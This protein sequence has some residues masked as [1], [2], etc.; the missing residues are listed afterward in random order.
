MN[1][2]IPNR[3]YLGW[4]P[5]NI[6][7]TSQALWYITNPRVMQILCAVLNS[8]LEAAKQST[9]HY[10]KTQQAKTLEKYRNEAVAIN[11]LFMKLIISLLADAKL[12][13]VSSLSSCLCAAGDISKGINYWWFAKVRIIFFSKCSLFTRRL[14]KHHQNANRVL[15]FA[16]LPFQM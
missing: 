15:G 3:E 5:P 14:N 7:C 16:V 10:W 13:S 4:K 2:D 9:L 6:S 11:Q 8:P 12:W 1:K